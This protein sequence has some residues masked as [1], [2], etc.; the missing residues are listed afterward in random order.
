MA[1][2]LIA[3]ERPALRVGATAAPGASTVCNVSVVVARVDGKPAPF[4]ANLWLSDAASGAGL[5]AVT[6]SGTIIAGASGL[7]MGTDIVAKKMFRIQTTL[8]GL[9]ILAITD[10]ARTPFVVCA[11]I[12]G[13]SYAL[14]TLATANYG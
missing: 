11:E 2:F 1:E 9:F 4:N 13:R 7:I 8:A 5:S 10:A 3:Q 12:E 6:A 14:I